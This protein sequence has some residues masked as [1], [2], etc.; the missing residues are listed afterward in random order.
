[1]ISRSRRTRR[2]K[3][4]M[5]A[6]VGPVEGEV[7]GAE[8]EV[9]VV[10][11]VGLEGEEG[12]DVGSDDT[13]MSPLGGKV[14]EEQCHWYLSSGKAFV[15]DQGILMASIP[16]GPRGSLYRHFGSKRGQGRAGH[17]KPTLYNQ[18]I[19]QQRTHKSQKRRL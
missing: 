4:E 8:G 3:R 7:Q 15:R 14:G 16:C 11:V 10:V 1:M 13:S 12:E 9:V 17:F 19:S 5:L 18:R 2:E 6:G